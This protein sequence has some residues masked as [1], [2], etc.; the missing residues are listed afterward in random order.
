MP[1]LSAINNNSST[2]SRR[3]KLRFCREAIEAK[4]EEA[5]RVGA[6]MKKLEEQESKARQIVD[7]LQQKI[8]DLKAEAD[9]LREL[10]KSGDADVR[11][12]PPVPRFESTFKTSQF[13]S[14]RVQQMLL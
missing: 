7:S 8:D 12:S 1:A 10:Q 11:D 4:K 9:R 6:A 3:P 13:G 14:F 5:A 2:I